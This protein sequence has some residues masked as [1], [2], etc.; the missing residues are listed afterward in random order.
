MSIVQRI[1]PSETILSR[2]NSSGIGIIDNTW[3]LFLLNLWQ[4]MSLGVMKVADLPVAGTIGRTAF[5]T[6]ANSST[7]HATAVGGGSNVV[8]VFDNGTAW[9]IG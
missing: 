7:F 6:D 4:N 1:P 5:V 2:A 3:Y 9:I 8:P